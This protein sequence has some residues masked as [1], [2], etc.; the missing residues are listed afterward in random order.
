[1]YNLWINQCE[2]LW[3]FVLEF[4]WGYL[5]GLFG[6]CIVEKRNQMEKVC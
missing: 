6:E 2:N 4:F 5:L 3:G 1:M